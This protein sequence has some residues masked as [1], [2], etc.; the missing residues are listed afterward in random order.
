[1]MSSQELSESTNQE[2]IQVELNVVDPIAPAH[3]Q[4]LVE[5]KQPLAT[6]TVTNHSKYRIISWEIRI[7][8]QGVSDWISFSGHSINH[9]DNEKLPL[10]FTFP[11]NKLYNHE[12]KNAFFEYEC[13]FVDE[14]GKEK[15]RAGTKIVR[16]LAKD[17]MIWALETKKGVEDLYPLIAAWVTPRDK[18]VQEIVHE[19]A[20][21]PIIEPYGGLIGYQKVPYTMKIS[22]VWTIQ[23]SNYGYQQLHLRAGTKLSINLK[24]IVGGI[25]NDI[26]F[27]ILDRNKMQAYCDALRRFD[28]SSVYSFTKR[29]NTSHNVTYEIQDADDYYIILDNFFSLLAAK[30]IE[31]VYQIV[32]PTTEVEIVANQIFAIYSTIM[33]RGFSYVN[34]T[35]SYAPGYAQRVK[36]P[37]NTLQLKGGNCIDGAVLYASCFE[38]IGLDSSV[39]L[40]PKKS[41]AIVAVRTWPNVGR[42]IYFDTTIN[43]ESP[44]GLFIS[45]AEI[46]DKS[47]T[48]AI[49]ISVNEARQKR[50]MPLA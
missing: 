44:D 32:A 31:L 5:N 43:T 23:P 28:Y 7:R 20:N 9:S 25:H 4:Y 26:N 50:I 39:I 18:H 46:Y 13:Y 35:I 19:S 47:K 17:D 48:D 27:A 40:L 42:M 1:M 15:K 34:T 37:A 2:S 33:K 3:F 22:S 14:K 45:S 30:K 6:V 21:H 29:I 38:A 24:Y 10:F 11:Q 8:L 49:W 41:H 12:E 16:I 36:R